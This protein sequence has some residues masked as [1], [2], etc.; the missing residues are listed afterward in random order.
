MSL[1]ISLII[2]EISGKQ[3]EN[4]TSDIGDVAIKY[5]FGNDPADV[6]EFDGE[7][8]IEFKSLIIISKIENDDLKIDEP[9]TI[10][11]PVESEK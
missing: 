9:T 2:P 3:L 7:S 6:H 10:A 5:G 11:I 4:I 8:L 1:K